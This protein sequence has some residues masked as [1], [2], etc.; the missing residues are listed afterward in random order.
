MRARQKK[1]RFCGNETTIKHCGFRFKGAFY[2]MPYCK[3]C[4][5]IFEEDVDRIINAMRSLDVKKNK[6]RVASDRRDCKTRN[7][8][9]Y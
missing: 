6:T 9:T 5:T 3:E 1:C 2:D 4:N 8:T 7:E